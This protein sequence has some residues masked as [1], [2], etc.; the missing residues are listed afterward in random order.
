VYSRKYQ[1]FYLRPLLHKTYPGENWNIIHSFEL[2]A[3][4]SDKVQKCTLKQGKL[5]AMQVKQ[6]KAFIL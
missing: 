4:Q 2:A 6:K 3:W 1:G 5:T